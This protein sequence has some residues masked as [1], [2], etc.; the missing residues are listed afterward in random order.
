M[1]GLGVIVRALS[2][3]AR[4]ADAKI[5]VRS[6]QITSLFWPLIFMVDH[7]L[8]KYCTLC[9]RDTHDITHSNILHENIEFN[10]SIL[11]FLG[12]LMLIEKKK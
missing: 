2:I 4:L 1:L 8:D 6:I 12:H 11:L 5:R 3:E 10:L 9:T 7:Y